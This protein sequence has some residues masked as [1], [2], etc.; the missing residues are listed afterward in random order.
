MT[1]WLF[2]WPNDWVIIYFYC[3]LSIR[4]SN[5]AICIRKAFGL[6][7]WFIMTKW[8]FYDEMTVIW[9]NGFKIINFT[10][11]LSIRMSNEMTYVKEVFWL[12][13][14]FRLWQNYCFV[15]KW[16]CHLSFYEILSIRTSNMITFVSY[17]L[18]LKSTFATGKVRTRVPYTLSSP[19]ARSITV[20]QI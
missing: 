12:D 15:T 20:T 4:I 3:I 14:W 9:T 1:Q 11:M 18:L 2:L 17:Y 10:Y 16:T 19:Q 7:A 8:L 5:E 13:T 6:D